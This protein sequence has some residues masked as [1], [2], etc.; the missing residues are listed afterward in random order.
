MSVCSLQAHALAFHVHAVPDHSGMER[1]SHAPAIH[2]HG[3][4]DDLDD[5]LHLEAD[6]ESEGAVITVVVPPITAWSSIDAFIELAAS[7][8]APLMQVIGE[9]RAIEVR[10]H[11]PPPA[12]DAALRGPPS[13]TLL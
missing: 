13:S 3:H 9:A 11:G 4:S 7:L 5:T 12:R 1:H 2:H 6:E 8:E 10:S